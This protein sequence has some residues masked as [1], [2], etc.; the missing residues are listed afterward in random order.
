M[1]RILPLALLAAMAACAPAPESSIPGPAPVGLAPDGGPFSVVVLIGDGTGLTYWSALDVYSDQPLAIESFPVVGLVDTE[2]SNSKITDSAAS[3]T[4]FSAGVRTYNGAVGVGPDT[5]AVTTVVEIAESLGWATGLVATSRI[6]HAT[7]ASFIAHV[8]SRQ[9][10]DE[11]A[12]QMA[13]SGVEVMLGGGTDYFDPAVRQDGRDLIDV[14]GQRGAYVAS[15][16]AFRSLDLDTVSTLTG[17][18]GRRDMAAAPTRS[19]SLPEMTEAALGILG[20]D[21]DGFFLM[22]EASQ[23]DW[24]GHE[25]ARLPDL[26]AEIQDFDRTLQRA[27]AYQERHPNT[28]L[29]VLADHSTGGLSI[30][31]DSLGVLDAF[32]TT[33]G[34]TAE[35]TPMFARGPGA[36]AFGG[37]MD[38]DRVGRILLDLVRGGGIGGGSAAP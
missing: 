30:A 13:T 17:L 21:P 38:N 19:P 31:P 8:P 16:R 28:L 34:H 2:S 10:Y 37:V 4:A 9:M 18:F 7:P 20:R 1:N 11:I 29:L 35:L 26:L 6:T 5:T 14:L 22:V 3:A 32:Y 25:N 15:A 24:R 23:I 27:L 12:V 33:E 36:Q